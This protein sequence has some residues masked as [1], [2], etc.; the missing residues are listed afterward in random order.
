M[1]VAFEEVTLD[2]HNVSDEVLKT[3]KYDERSLS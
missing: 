3:F 1:G 2:F